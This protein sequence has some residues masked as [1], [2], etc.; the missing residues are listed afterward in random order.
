MDM[1]RRGFL[2]GALTAGAMACATKANA[3]SFSSLFGGV[4]GAPMH[5]YAAPKI[6]HIRLGIVG[7]GGRGQ[8]VMERIKGLPGI[9]VV[10]ICDCNPKKIAESQ[11]RLANA[12]KAKEYLG[13]EAWRQLCDDPNVDVVYNTTPWEL[14]VPVALAAMKGGKHV[15]TEVPSAF[16]VDE[17]WELVETSEKTKMHC[18]QL[19][20]CCY[21]EIEMLTFNLAKLG[22]LGDIIHGEGA[23]IHDLRN[24]CLAN[25]P[26]YEYWRY[27]HNRDHAGNRYATHGLVP[28]CLT[29]DVNRGDRLD[30]LVS[31]DSR[32][33]NFRLYKDNHLKKDDPR[34]AEAMKTGDM[35]TSLIRTV[36]GKTMMIQHDVSSPRPYTRIQL[37]SGTKGIVKDYPFQIALEPKNGAGAHGWYTQQAANEIAAKY[38]HPLYKTIGE[39]AKRVGGHGGMDFIMDARWIYCLQQGLPLDMDVYD[40]AATSCLCELTEKSVRSGSKP[41]SIP[42]FTRGNWKN[43]QPWGIVN[44]DLE[45]MG[46]G[47]DNVSNDNAALSV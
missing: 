38:M 19:E 28:L 2:T 11:Q 6:P 44:V 43:V 42:D 21:G 13:T 20:N 39:L 34:F 1:N 14:H 18:M 16:T 5:G 10:A 41:V 7:M 29:M 37:V 9:D 23:Y 25:Y 12:G 33:L 8:G 46:I 24:M 31:M 26:D 47:V 3:F 36:K 17:C 30:Y 22:M 45:K 32:E 40:L 15:F 35:N 27:P 4:S